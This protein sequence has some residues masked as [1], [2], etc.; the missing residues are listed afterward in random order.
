VAGRVIAAVRNKAKVIVD[1]GGGWG[2]S[3]YDHLKAL[4]IPVSGFR[5]A[6]STAKRTKDSMLGY[7][8]VRAQ[9]WWQ[10]REA[11]DPSQQGGSPIALPPDPELVADLTAPTYDTNTGKIKVERKEDL[12]KRLGRSPDKGDA[13]VM[14]WYDGSKLETHGRRWGKYSEEHG[15]GGKKAPKVVMSRPNARRRRS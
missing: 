10:F 5:P 8:N 7:Y 2:G 3:T 11:L 4:D 15:I 6:E 9:A 12:K 1:M 13:V 14:A